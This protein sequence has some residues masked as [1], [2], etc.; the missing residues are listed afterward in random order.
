[1]SAPNP[2]LWLT[3]LAAW[4][5]DPAEKALDLLRDPAGH[6]GGTVRELRQQIFPAGVPGT[7]EQAVLRADHWAAAADRPQFGNGGR[8][9]WAQVRFDQRPVGGSVSE[10]R[11]HVG[12]G[13]RAYFTDRKSV[14]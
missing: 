8:E 6:E 13:Y 5:H 1:M 11:V 14:V 9:Q 10:M 2:T 4:S 3:K 7:I 12:P